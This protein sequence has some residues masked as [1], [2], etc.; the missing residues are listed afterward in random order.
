M[1]IFNVQ[2]GVQHCWK[3][4]SVQPHRVKYVVIVLN[5]YCPEAAG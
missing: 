2:G 4:G 3:A 1:R 5:G